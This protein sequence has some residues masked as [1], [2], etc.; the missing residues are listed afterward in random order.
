M[1]LFKLG[2]NRN[3][4]RKEGAAIFCALKVEAGLRCCGGLH[5]LLPICWLAL[6]HKA[7]PEPV[8]TSAPPGAPGPGQVCFR[9]MKKGTVFFFS[10]HYITWNW[11]GDRQT[12]VP[13]CPCGFQHFLDLN[14]PSAFSP[15]CWPSWSGEISGLCQGHSCLYLLPW[16]CVVL[17][18]DSS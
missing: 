10:G 14:L 5:M 11:G 16:L 3:M 2:H 15:D 18:L 6:G 12:P 1:I 7:V 8:A 4:L 17:M 9:P 13:L